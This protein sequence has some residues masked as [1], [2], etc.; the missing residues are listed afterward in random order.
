MRTTGQV[1]SSETLRY[2]REANPRVII[3]LDGSQAVGN[4]VVDHDVLQ[5]VDFYIGSG[6]KW[7]GGMPSSGFVWRRD[8]TRWEVADPAQ[9]LSY[10]GYLG[11]TGNAPAW[12]S[13]M[14]K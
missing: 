10:P 11:G 3:V 13:L 6:H 8:A 14:G 1:L 9:S 7:L 2:F 12:I 4:I 5:H